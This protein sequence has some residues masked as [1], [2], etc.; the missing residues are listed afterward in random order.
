VVQENHLCKSGA[1]VE[2]MKKG[3]PIDRVKRRST[4]S[5]GLA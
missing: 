5:I 3:R 1:V 4:Q 2:S